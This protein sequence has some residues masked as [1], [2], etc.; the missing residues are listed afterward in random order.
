MLLPDREGGL[1]LTGEDVPVPVPE[2]TPAFGLEGEDI[3]TGEY[4]VDFRGESLDFVCGGVAVPILIP[5]GSGLRFKGET[6][7][8]IAF[9]LEL[10]VTL[11]VRLNPVLARPRPNP[12][13]API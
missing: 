11:L 5:L 1:D 7:A 2:S 8:G 10:G 6:T 13:P 3:P 12:I 4:I 9:P